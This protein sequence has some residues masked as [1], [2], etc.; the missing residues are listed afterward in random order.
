V[1]GLADGRVAIYDWKSGAPPTDKEIGVFALQLL[2]EG[3]IAEAGGF[4]GVAAA[5][6]GRLE[7]LGLTG[8][9][10]GGRAQ[11]AD[12]DTHPLEQVAARLAELI[13]AYD[14]PD[15]PYRARLRPKFIKYPGDY[16][17]LARHGEWSDGGDAE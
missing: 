17:Q 5:R 13:A 1:V 3:V 15:R 10:E 6:V 8:S 7:Y 16:D 11:A 2:L 4:E 14:A 9:G 12:L